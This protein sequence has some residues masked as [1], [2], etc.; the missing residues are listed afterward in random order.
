[1]ADMLSFL[2]ISKGISVKISRIR[3]LK[4][5][6]VNKLQIRV[7]LTFS[8]SDGICNSTGCFCDFVWP[9]NIE[10]KF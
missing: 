8:V 9:V 6:N 4:I 7:K 1:M 10:E 3:Y 2:F 5:Y